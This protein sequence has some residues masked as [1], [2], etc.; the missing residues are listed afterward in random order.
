MSQHAILAGRSQSKAIDDDALV[1]PR[2]GGVSSVA[3]AT[4]AA[5][6][7]TRSDFARHAL[8]RDLKAARKSVALGGHAATHA[9]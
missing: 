9:A 8:I 7:I 6:G 1:A 2:R 4:A 5:E 3:E